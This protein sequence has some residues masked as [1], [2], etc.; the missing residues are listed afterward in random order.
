MHAVGRTLPAN[1]AAAQIT[2]HVA[3]LF[4]PVKRRAAVAEVGATHLLHLAWFA[5]HG[6]FWRAPE[7]VAWTGATG[8]LVQ[9]FAAA[10]GRRVVVAG[11]GAEYDWTGSG[12]LVEG[13]TPL[14]PAT[15]YGVCKDATRRLCEALGE[16]LGLEVA[17][18]RV[19]FLYGPGEDERR[20]VSGVARALVRGERAPTSAGT[21]VRD[22]MHVDDV[23]GAF[24]ALLDS[25][26]TGPLNIATGEGVAVRDL[27]ALIAR[28]AG[29]EELLDIGALP[30]REDEPPRLV[31]DGRRLRE[32]VGFEPAVTLEDGVAATV[33]DLL[34]AAARR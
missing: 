3:E 18:G 1:G 23:G 20:L 27:V 10:G 33:A 7:N 21:Q 19:F 25:A 26:A 8:E 11:T 15:L 28:A 6:R 17:W 29:A 31:G 16:E 4:D 22:F 13:E 2:W 30:M 24:A 14:R 5:E 9:E 34:R 12:V 32:E